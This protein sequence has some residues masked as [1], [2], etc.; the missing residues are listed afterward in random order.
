[1]KNLAV[2]GNKVGFDKHGVW[3]VGT[4]VDVLPAHPG[5]EALAVVNVEGVFLKV[6]EEALYELDADGEPYWWCDAY[7]MSLEMSK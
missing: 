3:S 5:Q 6:T 2:I 4:V 1:M 7:I